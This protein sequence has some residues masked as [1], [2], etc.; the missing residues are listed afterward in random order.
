MSE[1]WMTRTGWTLSAL[2][3]LFMVAASVAPK[4]L[5]D[6]GQQTMAAL[7]WPE[8]P[9]PLIGAL[10]L[11]CM[12]LFLI[13]RTALL[14]ATLTMAIFGGAIVTQMRADSPLFSHTLFSFYLGA[15]MWAGLWL[16]DPGI[17]AVWPI[18]RRFQSS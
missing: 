18:R 2:Y 8:A 1:K 12:L 11:V 16:R 14:G 4:F 10:E 7:G 13:P 15:L 6:I 17:R 5:T 3:A 9:V